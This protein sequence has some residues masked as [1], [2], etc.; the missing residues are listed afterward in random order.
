[1]NRKFRRTA[2]IWNIH[3]CNIINVFIITFKFNASLLNKSISF[4]VFSPKR[5]TINLSQAFEWYCHSNGFYV[6]SCFCSP[7]LFCSL[8]LVSV[9]F[10]WLCLCVCVCV[11]VCVNV[12]DASQW[13]CENKRSLCAVSSPQ[14]HWKYNTLSFSYWQHRSKTIPLKMF[15]ALPWIPKEQILAHFQHNC[16]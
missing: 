13:C 5:L 8:D 14:P 3:F 4:Y 16:L 11:C 9:S 7:A 10:D 1:M 2:F 15:G 6:L 12:S